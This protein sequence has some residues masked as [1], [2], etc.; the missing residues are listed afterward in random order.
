MVRPALTSAPARWCRA[1]TGATKGVLL[2]LPTEL[3]W[4][5]RQLALDHGTSLQALGVEAP[6]RILKVRRRQAA[7]GSPRVISTCPTWKSFRLCACPGTR[8]A[9]AE[10]GEPQSFYNAFFE[11]FGVRRRSVARYGEHVRK[12]G[13]RMNSAACRGRR[14]EP[15][16]IIVLIAI[17][18]SMESGL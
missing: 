18:A 10:K 6:Q 2:R 9:S 14:Y 13:G 8:C 5:L 4:Q 11:I 7:W 1:A 12:R 15:L 17:Y 3:H 16:H